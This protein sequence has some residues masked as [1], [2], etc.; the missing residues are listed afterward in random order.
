MGASKPLRLQNVFV[1]EKEI[2]DVAAHCKK[3]AEPSCRDDVA[4]GESRQGEA[5]AEIGAISNC[6]SRRPG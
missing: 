4:A 3:Q 5:D 6:W 1:T 2:R